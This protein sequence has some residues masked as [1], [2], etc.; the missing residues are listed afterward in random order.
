MKKAI[1][2]IVMMLLLAAGAGGVNVNA[3]VRAVVPEDGGIQPLYTDTQSAKVTLTISGGNVTATTSVKMLRKSDI[4]I[5]MKLQKKAGEYWLTI[6]TWEGS[7]ENALSYELSKPYTVASG[8]YRVQAVIKAG[9]D[10]ITKNS[11]T[12]T[13]G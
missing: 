1:C 7:K 11:A 5:T 2:I 3:A 10:S 9:A 12:K 4:A 13:V 6:K 8:S